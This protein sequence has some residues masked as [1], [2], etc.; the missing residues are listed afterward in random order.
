MVETR[1]IA[2]MKGLLILIKSY[3]KHICQKW[4]FDSVLGPERQKLTRKLR[5]WPY[6]QSR[7]C[8]KYNCQR[9][10]IFVSCNVIWYLNNHQVWLMYT[11][12][13]GI[14]QNRQIQFKM[15]YFCT[16]FQFF[17]FD[18]DPGAHTPYPKWFFFYRFGDLTNI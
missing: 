11:K 2:Q 1:A 8:K 4:I 16:L 9:V 6:L 12:I 3:K 18:C 13:E 17:V 7:F 10:A 14:M 15:C 5:N